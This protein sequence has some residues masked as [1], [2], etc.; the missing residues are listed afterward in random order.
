MIDI[1][2]RKG[3]SRMDSRIG[4]KPNTKLQLQNKENGTIVYYIIRELSRG[5]SCIVYEASEEMNSGD[6]K[7][8]RLKECY[9]Y[10]LNICREDNGVLVAK[11]DSEELFGRE[12]E[13][14]LSDFSTGNN[15][16]YTEELYDVLVSPINSYKANNTIYIAYGYSSK[17]TLREYHPSSI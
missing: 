5:G 17:H 8:I 3:G 12:K 15:L 1:P 7:I 14:F 16:F 6:K 2:M 9:P 4:L 11:E 10:A 13:R